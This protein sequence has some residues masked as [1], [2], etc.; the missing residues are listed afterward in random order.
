MNNQKTYDNVLDMV[1]DLFTEDEEFIK[2]L[3]DK[4]NSTRIS[5][6]LI[7]M[8]NDVNLTLEQINNNSEL[9]TR[10]LSF[11]TNI[12]RNLYDGVR[13]ILEK[14]K[15]G[16]FKLKSNI[17]YDKKIKLAADKIDSLIALNMRGKQNIIEMR[18]KFNVLKKQNTDAIN[19]LK[20]RLKWM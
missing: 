13:E 14:D 7:I 16:L 5:K 8:R 19:I 15:Y 17:V 11:D 6:Q 10:D 3:E 2:K 12:A 1:K 4:I 9:E 20:E 18:K